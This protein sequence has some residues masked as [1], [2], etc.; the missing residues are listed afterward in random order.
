[1]KYNRVKIKYNG[2]R[3]ARRYKHLIRECVN[4]VLKCEGVTVPCHVDVTITDNDGIYELNKK[5]MGKDR[6]TDVLSFPMQN[7]TAGA[8]SCDESEIDVETGRLPLGDIVISMER[9]KEQAREYGHPVKREVAYLTVHSMLHLLGYDH[10]D[11]GEDKKLMR[12]HEE[13]ALDLMGIT[14]E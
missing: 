11:E 10:M 3:P 14:R 9:A 5:F 6:P 1:M 2:N 4:T 13:K 7:L 12:Y 8:F